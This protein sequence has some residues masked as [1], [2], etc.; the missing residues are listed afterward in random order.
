MRCLRAP[1]WCPLKL[2]LTARMAGHGCARTARRCS[3]LST[4]RG[5]P[6]LSSGWTLNTRLRPPPVHRRIL[7][8]L[9]VRCVVRAF[10]RRTRV[11]VPNALLLTAPACANSSSV[12]AKWRIGMQRHWQSKR[13]RNACSS[14]RQYASS[15]GVF[16]ANPPRIPRLQLLQ[17]LTPRPVQCARI[18]IVISDVCVSDDFV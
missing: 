6:A 9:S 11:R 2:K 17:L 7:R 18:V 8:M 4:I 1:S 10:V 13:I 12:R 5:L 3:E 15:P 16:L 14:C